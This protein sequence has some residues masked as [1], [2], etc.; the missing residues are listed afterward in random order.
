LTAP[1]SGEPC[2]W[3][4]S[5]VVENTISDGGSTSLLWEAG[6]DM[7]FTV[8]DGS[9][10]VLVDGRL[11]HPGHRSSRVG[12]RPPVRRV[13]EEDVSSA[14]HSTHLRDLIARGVLRAESF[15]RGWLTSSLGWSVREYVLPA[16]EQIHVQGRPESRN[17][18]P[19]LGSRRHKHL[20]TGGTHA[21]L[22]GDTEQDV[23]TGSGCLLIGVFAGPLLFA[24]GYLLLRWH[25]G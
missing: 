12:H 20:V 21:Q 8:R 7:P 24:A 11:V 9:G 10:S 3:F 25:G 14:R 19:V 16:G 2:V 1:L 18:R 4:F 13:V 6:G 23:R 22:T 15:E 17:G 5:Q